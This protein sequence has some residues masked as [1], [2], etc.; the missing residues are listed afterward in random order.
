[1]C[2]KWP[3]KIM[4]LSIFLIYVIGSLFPG[5][6]RWN[7]SKYA[8]LTFLL[9]PPLSAKI[10]F[11]QLYFVTD[12]HS[13]WSLSNKEIKKSLIDFLSY[14]NPRL[15]G[16]WRTSYLLCLFLSFFLPQIWA[17]WVETI[18]VPHDWGM[19]RCSSH[20]FL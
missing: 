6:M 12:A 11:S 10:L 14:C 5:K 20:A 13:V 4:F 8:L 17:F 15:L 16:N 1:M 9:T 2:N 18:L 19:N 7:T 3:S